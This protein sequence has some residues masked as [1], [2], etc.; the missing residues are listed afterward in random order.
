MPGHYE[1]L[2]DVHLS[3]RAE[4]V[5]GSGTSQTEECSFWVYG[6]FFS[7]FYGLSDLRFSSDEA[8]SALDATCAFSS[9]G[10][11]NAGG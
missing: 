3:K 8:A 9:L 10:L 1:Q 7:N 6:I 5:F 4:A 2:A 11:S